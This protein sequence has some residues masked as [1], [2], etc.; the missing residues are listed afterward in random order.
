MPPTL[1]AVSTRAIL[2]EGAVRGVDPA[3]VLAAAG[4]P[5]FAERIR[6]A[7]AAAIWRSA[8]ARTPDPALV[9]HAAA[10]PR[11]GA[12]RLL[13]YLAA[14]APTVGEAFRQ[15]AAQFSFV[16][17]S[18]EVAFADDPRGTWLELR[19]P[20]HVPG[21]LD[22]ALAA[23]YLRTRA[24]TQV[25]FA[26]AALELG[27][28]RGDRDEYARMF[29]CAPRFARDRWALLVPR[30]TWQTENPRRDPDLL[31]LLVDYAHHLAPPAAGFLDEVRDAI[32]V[33]L[34]GAPALTATARHLAT[35]TRTLQRR[36]AE[37]GTTF[38]AAV[39]AARLETARDLLLDSELS[40]N[41]IAQ[42]V[43]YAQTS[44][45]TRAFGRWLKQSP[46]QFRRA[47]RPGDRS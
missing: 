34:P 8:L 5:A 2:D 44:S 21:Y 46:R 31:A 42:R 20:A 12:Y 13:D 45:F 9:L 47:N 11:F 27:S 7:S 35:S 19:A 43:G 4:A 37:A 30:A 17:P 41:E 36:L 33:Q 25:D 22:Y 23:F 40:V 10:R 18:I 32:R 1:L 16:N 38:H 3:D 15:V 14:S 26:A 39:E 29:G 6:P 24:A 28:S